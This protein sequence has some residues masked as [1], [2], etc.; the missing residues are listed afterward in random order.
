MAANKLD[1]SMMEDVD[2]SKLTGSVPSAALGNVDLSKL[3]YN[4]AILAF[5][6][7]SA[8]Q[9]AKFSMVDQVIDEYQDA[10]GIDA[11]NSTGEIT[12]GSGTAKYYEGGTTV[13]PSVSG[14]YDSATVDGDY[15][16][17]KWTTVRSDGTYT[18]DTSQTYDFLV[19]AGGGSG[20]AP[21]PSHGGAG[22]GGGGAGG[23]R[24]SFGSEASGGGASSE[25][26]LTFTGTISNI[27]VGA[28]GATT[29]YYDQGN[30]GGNSVFSTITSIGGG[31]GGLAANENLG[32]T[33]TDGS[34]GGSAGG[35][36]AGETTVYTSSPSNAT[37]NQGY[38]GGVTATTDQGA[39]GGGAGSIGGN[40]VS[41]GQVGGPGGAVCVPSVP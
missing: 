37:A 41:S 32:G 16:Y 9:L 3:E 26:A 6:V 21:S 4:Q 11:G 33:P 19:I 30:V 29:G 14:N 24:N 22:G 15:T 40:G 20:G 23:F 5:K 36:G 38:P 39:G 1:G 35:Y 18:T 10:T 34:S 27:T 25:T 2:A 12:G 28:G 17:Y 8:N 7:A 31:S 13:T